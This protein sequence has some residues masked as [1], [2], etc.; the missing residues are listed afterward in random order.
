[1]QE[2]LVNPPCEL[3]QP[4]MDL[5]SQMRCNTRVELLADKLASSTSRGLKPAR[6]KLI[7]PTS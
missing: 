1:M 4:S 6:L 2:S 3:E 7:E 5:L